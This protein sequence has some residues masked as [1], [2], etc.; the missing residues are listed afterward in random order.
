ML[1]GTSLSNAL[2]P[3]KH[4]VLEIFGKK[5]SS[6]GAVLKGTAG[7]NMWAR[8]TINYWLASGF[9]GTPGITSHHDVR[10]KAPVWLEKEYSSFSTSCSNISSLDCRFGWERLSFSAGALCARQAMRYEVPVLATLCG[11]GNILCLK[12]LA[13]STQVLVHCWKAQLGII[14]ERANHYKSLVGSGIWKH[15]S[16]SLTGKR[17]QLFFDFLL[18]HLKL[19]LSVLLGK[20]ELV[21]WRSLC[22]AGKATLCG[23]GSIMRSKYLFC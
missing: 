13:K 23:W 2:L 11:W 20:A 8:S 22:K 12:Y 9:E 16:N 4:T 21:S 14:Y 19:R 5:H 17:I 10:M 18:K 15:T 7:H 6:A 3:S 1:P